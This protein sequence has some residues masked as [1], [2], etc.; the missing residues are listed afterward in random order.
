MEWPFAL[1]FLV[2][3]LIA[4]MAVG[5][6]VAFCFIVVDLIGVYVFWGGLVG[7]EQLIHTI[8]ESLS[9]FT[10]LPLPLFVLMGEVM[11][12]SGVAPNMI[13]RCPG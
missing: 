13:D 1:L 4:M 6:P 9:T 8:F 5:L 3:T 2:G 7:L 12:L 10:L 11:F